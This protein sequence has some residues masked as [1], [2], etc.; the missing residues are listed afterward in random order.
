MITMSALT[1][2]D[3]DFHLAWRTLHLIFAQWFW[4]HGCS[5]I[6]L[7]HS[8]EAISNQRQ[9]W[10]NLFFKVKGNAEALKTAESNGI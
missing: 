8:D 9:K 2:F 5:V 4:H 7:I 10:G 3:S 1:F 6:N